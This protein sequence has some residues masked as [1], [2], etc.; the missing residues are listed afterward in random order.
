VNIIGFALL[1]LLFLFVT[2]NDIKGLIKW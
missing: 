1:M 2:Y